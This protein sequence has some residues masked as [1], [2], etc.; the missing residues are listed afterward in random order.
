MQTS[1]SQKFNPNIRSVETLTRMKPSALSLSLSFCLLS[2]ISCAL[3]FM[4]E[5]HVCSSPSVRQIAGEMDVSVSAASSLSGALC[6]SGCLEV[7]WLP[8]HTWLVFESL[9]FCFGKAGLVYFYLDVFAAVLRCWV[10]RI[11]LFIL[12][13]STLKYVNK[14]IKCPRYCDDSIWLHGCLFFLSFFL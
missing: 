8:N 2:L 12:K 3:F 14:L 7:F 10:S 6:T 11:Y 4:H 5:G 1:R 9:R 13:I